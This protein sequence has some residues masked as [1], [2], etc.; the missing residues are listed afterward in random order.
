MADVQPMTG[1]RRAR[2]EPV[3]LALLTALTAL[4][5]G[6]V[7]TMVYFLSQREGSVT[8]GE[9]QLAA[10][11]DAAVV[12]V[13]HSLGERSAALACFTSD[14]T[15]DE[16]LSSVVEPSS[17]GESTEEEEPSAALTKA[18][19][20]ARGKVRSR[21]ETFCAS[22]KGCRRMVVSNATNNIVVST[23]S[24]DE[25]GSLG[26]TLVASSLESAE[27]VLLVGQAL[28]SQFGAPAVVAVRSST[29]QFALLASFEMET[30]FQRL[31]K[32][33][34]E[35]G[36]SARVL[37]VDNRRQ[38]LLGGHAQ[39]DGKALE[40][41]AVTRAVKGES[42]VVRTADEDDQVVVAAF[43]PIAEAGL[44][45]VAMQPLEQLQS[46]GAAFSWGGVIGALIVGLVGAVVVLLL[47]WREWSNLTMLHE[48][49]QR[50]IAG[51]INERVPVM[52]DD[53]VAIIS[54][55]LN[56]TLEQLRRGRTPRGGPGGG[57]E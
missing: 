32:L 35:L 6:L 28:D 21:L 24:G 18:R 36:L 9:Q 54:Q 16:A 7:P 42:A 34:E 26:G 55:A 23:E 31:T 47:G 52:G 10:L 1:N 44:V 17:D 11:A 33:R 30:V 3:R 15:L 37:V 13:R 39:H 20:A 49:A 51:D 46:A 25:G 5:A 57:R 40:I 8:Q 50:V 14:A 4:V 12:G 45:T 38:P 22:Q 56:S 53:E 41:E 48:A 43:R 29:K 2:S 27:P 19:E